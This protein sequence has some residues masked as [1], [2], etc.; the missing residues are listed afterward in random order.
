MDEIIT[1]PGRTHARRRIGRRPIGRADQRPTPRS[2]RRRAPNGAIAAGRLAGGQR[3]ATLSP[4][5]IAVIHRA[6]YRQIA[7]C[8][9]PGSAKSDQ[10]ALR[11][12]AVRYRAA[13]IGRLW[14]GRFD[15]R[16]VNTAPGTVPMAPGSIYG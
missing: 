2:G 13:A 10:T 16:P 11:H 3:D 9:A 1:A 14:G 12:A 8:A 5:Q 15:W 7:I 4:S 6:D